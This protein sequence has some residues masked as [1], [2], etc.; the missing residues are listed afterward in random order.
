MASGLGHGSMSL[1]LKFIRL[2][3]ILLNMVFVIIGI[4]IITIGIFLIKNPKIQ[5]LRPLLNPDL[6]SK[7]PQSLSN[8]EIFTI[9]LIV[10]GGVSLIIGFLGNKKYKMK[11]IYYL[12]FT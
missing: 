12:T 11:F 5:Q 3:I 4:I 10:S 2:L 1:S 6:I 7:Y 8:I 9:V